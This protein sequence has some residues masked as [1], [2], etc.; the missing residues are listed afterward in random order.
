MH[1]V[2]YAHRFLK[3]IEDGEFLFFGVFD[4]DGLFLGGVPGEIRDS[5]FYAHMFFRR[6]VDCVK[7]TLLIEEEIKKYCA[8]NDIPLK[9]I[10]G[11]TPET[12]TAALRMAKKAGYKD[13]GMAPEE[14]L[15]K[16]GKKIPCRFMK[17]EI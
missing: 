3:N 11:F 6:K 10:A 1:D 15:L 2:W 17:K 8:G 9:A 16:N 7:A 5:V 13:C 12:Y 14:F 4:D